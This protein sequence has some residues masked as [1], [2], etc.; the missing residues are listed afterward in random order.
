MTAEAEILVHV[1]GPDGR[2]VERMVPLRRA[3]AG[4]GL[5]AEQIATLRANEAGLQ[6]EWAGGPTYDPVPV[7]RLQV[8]P[9][10][11]LLGSVNAEGMAFGLC[12]LNAGYPELGLVAVAE[13]LQVGASAASSFDAEGR[14]LT[15]WASRASR[16]HRIPDRYGD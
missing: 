10:A 3:L 2:R 13:L 5:T 9:C 6:V 11:W 7:V 1:E 14:T 16:L 4:L 15:E 12:D 8:G